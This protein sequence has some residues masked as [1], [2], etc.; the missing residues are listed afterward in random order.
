VKVISA[1]I[2]T[3]FYFDII[4]TCLYFCWLDLLIVH[5]WCVGTPYNHPTPQNFINVNGTSVLESINNWETVHQGITHPR[6]I[7]TFQFWSYDLSGVRAA[8]I[9]GPSL[10][11]GMLKYEDGTGGSHDWQTEAK[12][13]FAWLFELDSKYWCINF[14]LRLTIDTNIYLY[15][16]EPHKKTKSKCTWSKCKFGVCSQII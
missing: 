16:T 9:V 1:S 12:I 10:I 7:T 13:H 3:I 6:K 4:Q 5:H 15:L 2:S 8:Y 11:S 14:F